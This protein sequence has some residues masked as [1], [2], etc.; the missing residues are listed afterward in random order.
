LTCVVIEAG[1]AGRRLW[2]NWTS[3]DVSR[4]LWIRKWQ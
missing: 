1:T 4:W 3:K 2:T